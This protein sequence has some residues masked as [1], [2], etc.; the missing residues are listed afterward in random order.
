[1]DSSRSSFAREALILAQSRQNGRSI[2][3]GYDKLRGMKL[4]ARALLALGLA[5]AAG[6]ASPGPH[7]AFDPHA[8][9][10]VHRDVRVEWWYHWGFLQDD[11]GGRWA[12][13]SSF[14]RAHKPGL[15]VTRY[16]LYDLTDLATGGRYA[17]SPA[18]AGNLP[19][20]RSPTR[21][22]KLPQPPPLSPLPP[23]AK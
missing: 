3:F 19:L 18:G 15:P 13:F 5:A 12:C 6:C 16:Y 2:L 17:R 22:G 14:F 7:W 11:A 21:G 9:E 23:P 8:E 20:F 4:G 10:G 1:M